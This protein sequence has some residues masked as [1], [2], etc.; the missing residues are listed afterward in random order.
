MGSGAGEVPAEPSAASPREAGAAGHRPLL[1]Q[2]RE[3]PGR[4]D[5]ITAKIRFTNEAHG[6]SNFAVTHSP[7]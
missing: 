6:R 2:G 7:L 5:G 4:R 1:L 3:H